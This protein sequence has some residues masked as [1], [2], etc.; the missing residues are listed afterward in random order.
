LAVGRARQALASGERARA[1]AIVDRRR[2]E[3]A[4]A[5]ELVALHRRLLLL[6]NLPLAVGVLLA[7]AAGVLAG[8]LGVWRQVQQRRM[9]ALQAR[10]DR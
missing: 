9:Q 3:S 2:R 10:L 6:E 1:R 5:P 8:A 4:E 7:A